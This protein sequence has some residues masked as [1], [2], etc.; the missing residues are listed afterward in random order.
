M[1]T[2]RGVPPDGEIWN[3]PYGEST[4]ENLISTRSIQKRYE[5]LTGK[6]AEVRDIAALGIKDPNVSRTF[7]SFGK[8]L[9]E[10]LRHTCA[11][12]APQRIVLGGGISRAAGLFLA[13]AEKELADL[14]I[15]LRVSDLLE[16]APLIGAGVS[17]KW[18]HLS[19]K[20]IRTK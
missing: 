20:E 3:L 9:G 7:E 12:F 13:A 1:V 8:E 18:H 19:R 11:E 17:W 15:Q 14:N 10:V 16:R 2:G 6:S 5:Q 4:V